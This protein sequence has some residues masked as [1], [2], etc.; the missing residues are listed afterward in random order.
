[1]TTKSK[2]KRERKQAPWGPFPL[3]LK[4]NL[5]IGVSFLLTMG[6]FLLLAYRSERAFQIDHTTRLMRAALASIALSVDGNG[7][8]TRL[9][10]L[11]EGL[12]AAGSHRHRLYLVDREG[13]VLASRDPRDHGRLLAEIFSTPAHRARE[14]D[15]A[16]VSN[17]RTTWLQVGRPVS[18]GRALYLLLDW[19][20]VAGN[21]RGFWTSHSAHVFVTLAIFSAL[22]WLISHRFI[23]APLLAL[24]AA[25][26]KIEMGIWA[27]GLEVHTRDE[28]GWLCARFNEMAERLKANVDRLVRVEKYASAAIIA[29]R[30]G[31]ELREPLVHMRRHV[32]T[33]TE[34]FGDERMISMIAVDLDRSLLEID[35]VLRGLS[36][37][38]HPDEWHA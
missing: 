9:A 21:L 11:Q 23:H 6:V 24:V 27:P 4:L 15:W 3:F 25:T 38:R 12:D 20:H 18:D 19:S 8:E 5:A 1:M 14:A 36:D 26:K 22:L 30:V 17:G 33:M 32:S 2:A 16:L 28:F 34:L 37:I 35:R 10:T 31:R 7:A 13:R 29:I